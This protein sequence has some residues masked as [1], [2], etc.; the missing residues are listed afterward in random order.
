MSA[1]YVSDTEVMKF[2]GEVIELIKTCNGCI[3]I[4]HGKL[5]EIKF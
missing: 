1:Y 5:H 3:V 2:N 4:N